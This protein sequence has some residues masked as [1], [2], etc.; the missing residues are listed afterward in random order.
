MPTVKFVREKQEVEVA[1]GANLRQVALDAGIQLYPG[2]HAKVNCLG[3]G[4]CG[5][6][7]VLL[8][9]D[10]A[11]NAAPK[12]LLERLRLAVGW[13]AIGHEEEARLACQTGVRGDLVVRTQPKFN[14]T[15]I[16]ARK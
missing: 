8:E 12:G 15:G 1:E 9:K 14:W 6:C 16:P 4:S 13:A 11:P 10:T 5:S 7:M 2:I 3:N